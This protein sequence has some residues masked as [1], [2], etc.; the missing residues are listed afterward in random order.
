MRIA[1]VASAFPPQYYPQ[2]E[3]AAALQD[4]WVDKLDRP[5]YLERFLNRVGVDG[6]QLALPIE[7]QYEAF[8]SMLAIYT[9]SKSPLD[10]GVGQALRLGWDLIHA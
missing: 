5:E 3:I 1:G 8:D 6:R 9:S 7:R 2:A 4:H 10:F